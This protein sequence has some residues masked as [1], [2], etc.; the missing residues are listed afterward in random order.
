MLFQECL[1]LCISKTDWQSK[2][3]WVV[4]FYTA[5]KRR[6]PMVENGGS[7]FQKNMWAAVHKKNTDMIT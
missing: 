3:L 4:E 5:I 6:Q 1:Q 7:D 2:S